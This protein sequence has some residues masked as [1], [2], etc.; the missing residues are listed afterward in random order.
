VGQHR[1]RRVH[2]GAL[3]AAAVRFAL[4]CSD[5]SSVVLGPRNAIQLDQLLREGNQQPPYLTD[6][7]LSS[8]VF[9]LRQLGVTS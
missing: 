3:R 9:R 1:V 2:P 8:L 6:E 5:V 4:A 7:Q